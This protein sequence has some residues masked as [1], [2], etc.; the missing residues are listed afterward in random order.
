MLTHLSIRNIVLI[1]RLELQFN[2]GL[3]V[4]TG[5]T[6]AGK[7][8]LLDA[9]GLA[10]GHRADFSLIRKGANKASVTAQFDIHPDHPLWDMLITIDID[11]DEDLIFRRLLRDDGKSSAYINDRLVSVGLLKQCSAQLIEIQ[12]QFEGHGLLDVSTHINLIDRAAGHDKQLDKL[13]QNWHSLQT[14][15]DKLTAEREAQAKAREDEDWLR[16]AVGQL[17]QLDAKI[18][19]ENQLAQDHTRHLHSA[20]ITQSLQ[21]ALEMISGEGNALS[22]AARAQNLLERQSEVAGGLLDEAIAALN[23]A[24][25]ELNEAEAQI[26]E[27]GHINEG[28]PE[29][30]TALEERL[31]NL[32]AMARKHQIETDELPALQEKLTSRLAALDDGGDRLNQLVANEQ[33]AYCDYCA[34][35]D[36]LS[37]NR[38]KTAKKLDQAMISELPPLKLEHAEF[39]TLFNKLDEPLW[40]EKGWDK[41]RFT[42]NTNQGMAIGALDKIASGGELARFL[43]ALK[44]VLAGNELPKT[45]I[46][47]EVDSGVGGAVASAVGSRLARLGQYTQTI[48]VTHS[49]QVAGKG[50]NHLKL[51]KQESENGTVST[52]TTLNGEARTEEI[53]RMLSADKITVEARAAARNLLEPS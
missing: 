33:H 30:L 18:G 15:R 32:R 4:F 26:T 2:G 17:D 46:F 12:G 28:N 52:V 8:I 16:D 31:H 23:R 21:Q 39:K 53:A 7:S 3:T 5:E 24:M 51:S 9:L 25:T 11:R 48:V 1:D 35:A 49:P 38:Q 37:E 27:A 10:L 42:A 6:G 13:R 47:D 40:S 29:H 14:A 50:N 44:V 43:L 36:K 45:L 22:N 20:R 19:E 41:V 34:L